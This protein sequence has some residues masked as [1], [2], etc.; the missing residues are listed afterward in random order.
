MRQRVWLYEN[1]KVC[2]NLRQ[3]LDTVSQGDAH[4]LYYHKYARLA[5]IKAAITFPLTRIG[6]LVSYPATYLQKMYYRFKKVSSCNYAIND[7]I[8]GFVPRIYKDGYYKK[9]K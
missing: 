3:V 2:S 4:I 5:R 6:W 1:A 7:R 8:I 9:Y